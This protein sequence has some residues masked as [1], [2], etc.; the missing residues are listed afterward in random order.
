MSDHETYTLL[1]FTPVVLS[2]QLLCI[3]ASCKVHD[4]PSILFKTKDRQP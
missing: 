3:L 1:Q 4:L 2:L